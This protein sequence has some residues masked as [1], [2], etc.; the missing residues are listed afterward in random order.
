MIGKRPVRWELALIAATSVACGTAGW[1]A[2]WS[3]VPN[4]DEGFL[5]LSLREW[6]QRGHLYNKVFSQYG[7]FYYFVFGLP[8]R[9]V[10]ANWTIESGRATNLALWIATAF[11]VG[12]AVTRITQRVTLAAAATLA[13]FSLLRVFAGEPMHPEAL[14][15][16]LLAALLASVTVIRA[17]NPRTGDFVAGGLVAAMALT[18]I[19]VGTFAVVAVAFAGIASMPRTRRTRWIRIAID[20]ILVALGPLLLLAQK[21]ALTVPVPEPHVFGFAE[22]KLKYAALYVA[23]AMVVVVASRLHA[24]GSGEDAPSR[25]RIGAAISGLFAV[26]VPTVF[27][28]LA[29]GTTVSALIDNIVLR[30]S[31]YPSV[32]QLPIRFSSI[33]LLWLVVV[34]V[35]FLAHNVLG[36]AATWKVRCAL[37]GGA[38]LVL[39]LAAVALPLG[40]TFNFFVAD[41]SPFSFLPV[42]GLV[43]V[44]RLSRE[45]PSDGYIFARRFV[46]AAAITNSLLAYPAPGDQIAYGLFLSLVCGAI[47][48]SDGITELVDSGILRGLARVAPGV[49]TVLLLAIPLSFPFGL[50]ERATYPGRQFVDWAQKYRRGTALDLVGTGRIRVE[51]LAA[52]IL[53]GYAGP[54]R[55]HCDTFVAFP[56]ML[57]LYVVTGIRPPTGFNSTANPLYLTAGEQN[58]VVHQLRANRSRL[59]LMLGGN[60]RSSLVDG[61]LRRLTTG[62]LYINSPLGRIADPTKA[63]PLLRYLFTQRW[64]PFGVV[65]AFQLWRIDR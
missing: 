30:P 12:V 52:A 60:Y 20:L 24:D 4:G 33:L 26:I 44:P 56:D 7:P 28:A 2:M 22:W 27:F 32:I 1:Y 9:A 8:A 59:C 29:T 10:G 41:G 46:A 38:R 50:H 13:T 3:S 39:G 14:L 21:T 48:I 5:I 31:Q 61:H 47:V 53:R 17:R 25:F 16:F 11:L 51:P 63:G 6:V 64:R 49:C 45:R 57:H 36:S 55:R 62:P 65:M 42:A 23:A 19:N 15:G 40:A 58:E 43:L 35:C 18:K 34:P 54:L 37:S